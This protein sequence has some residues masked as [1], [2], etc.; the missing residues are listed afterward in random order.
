[1]WFEGKPLKWEEPSE[2]LVKFFEENEHIIP[3][4]AG[5][6]DPGLINEEAQDIMD[7]TYL[8]Y[9][10]VELNV[11]YKDIF[12]EANHLLYTACFTAHRP[13]S[14]GW[15][16]LAVHGISSV[17]TNC[18]EDYGLPDDAEYTMSD[19]TDIA[20]FCP[21]TVEWMKDEVAYEK[22]TR[23]RFM[24]VLPGGWLAPHADRP[25]IKGV[26]ATNVAINNPEG[27]AMVMK[28]WGV[29]PLEAG[30][31]VKLNTGYEHAVWN[32]SD[33]PRI[34]MIFDGDPS[35]SFREKVKQ[36]YAKMLNV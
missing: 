12:E 34:H 7:D 36:G 5:V 15:L 4:L 10:P 29:T 26:G 9:I 19:W 17:H 20:K 6:D 24:A 25:R 16:S 1:M 13:C 22:F 31:A 18:A 27:C 35:D 23:V 3:D 2:E 11:P 21:H 14:S 32:R 30:S 28:G 33:E 8:P